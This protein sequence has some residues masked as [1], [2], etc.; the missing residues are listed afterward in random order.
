M[1]RRGWHRR[2]RRHHRRHRHRCCRRR[3]RL[4]S[5]RALVLV[6]ISNSY[7]I[8]WVLLGA[9][10]SCYYLPLL[11]SANTR[12]RGEDGG[13]HPLPARGTCRN[14]YSPRT[15]FALFPRGFFAPF[16]P[17]F[18]PNHGLSFRRD[19]SWWTSK[20]QHYMLVFPKVE[21]VHS[22]C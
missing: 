6:D 18:P 14:T 21:W 22:D 10:E 2:C 11:S 15:R 5:A 20:I 16:L 8:S 17:P 7:V 4:A 9:P 19:E 12:I 3:R 13:D 1:A